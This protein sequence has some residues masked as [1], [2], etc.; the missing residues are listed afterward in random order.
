MTTTPQTQIAQSI[1]SQ[2][3]KRAQEIVWLSAGG[4]KVRDTCEHPK[5][6]G[7]DADF[8]QVCRIWWVN[9]FEREKY[10]ARKRDGINHS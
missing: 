10:S 8:C 6:P 9:A 5:I 4:S 2:S 1:L 3:S 7:L